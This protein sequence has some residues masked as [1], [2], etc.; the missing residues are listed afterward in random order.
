MP[1]ECKYKN[2]GQSL[3]T[4]SRV[5]RLQSQS[6]DSSTALNSLQTSTGTRVSLHKTTII[7]EHP[8]GPGSTLRYARLRTLHMVGVEKGTPCFTMQKQQ[9]TP[10]HVRGTGLQPPTVSG[11]S[12]SLQPE[13]R[14]CTILHIVLHVKGRVTTSKVQQPQDC[15]S[16]QTRC[17]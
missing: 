10:T 7:V 9:D 13:S 3:S 16:L 11:A 6:T 17:Q 14:D 8:T 2:A 4:Q 12:A 5:H 1:L 15:A